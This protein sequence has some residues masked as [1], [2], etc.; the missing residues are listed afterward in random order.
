[1]PSKS[2]L[3]QGFES[4]SPGA[5]LLGTNGLEASSPKSAITQWQRYP[6]IDF[7]KMMRI[8]TPEDA[9]R[10]GA[11]LARLEAVATSRDEMWQPRSQAFPAATPT[12]GTWPRATT[13]SQAI[14]IFHCKNRDQ[15]AIL[16]QL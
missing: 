12:V 7:N 10:K 2:A 6:E 3:A 16:H 4:F 8:S 5:P 9:V 11:L 1:M 13:R 15:P 14:S